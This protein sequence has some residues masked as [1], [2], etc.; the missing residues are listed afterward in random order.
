MAEAL[1]ALESLV[2][3]LAAFGGLT[4]ENMAHGQGWRFLE[5]GRRLERA[6]HTATLLRATLVPVVPHG[7][8]AVLLES[9]LTVT[10]SLIAYRQR[11]RS[12]PRVDAL[13][14]LLLYDEDN[15]RALVFQLARM[16]D[17]VARLPREA[18]RQH[19]SR[20]GRLALEALSEVRL[21]DPT[22][23]ISVG[24]GGGARGQ[25]SGLLARLQR[26]LP[27]LS[28]AVAAAFFRHEEQPHLLVRLGGVE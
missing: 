9:V 14:D 8:E 17:L 20:E 2:G 12:G 24:E 10:D 23:L 25:L 22:L 3:A 19:R 16:H 4:A 1:E 7:V 21:S 6:L 27:R 5:L 11:Y 26:L 28:D 18:S 15:P 13:L